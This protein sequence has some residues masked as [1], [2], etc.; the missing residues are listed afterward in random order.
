MLNAS[1]PKTLPV[2]VH[3]RAEQ[4]TWLTPA[5]PLG[6]AAHL[7]GEALLDARLEVVVLVLVAGILGEVQLL[8]LGQGQAI[9][10]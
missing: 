4:A 7:P 10:V 9:V 1:Q 3:L 8:N 6:P 5:V 2:L